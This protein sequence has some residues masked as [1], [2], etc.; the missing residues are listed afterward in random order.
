MGFRNLR[1]V[2]NITFAP[3]PFVSFLTLGL[4]CCFSHSVSNNNLCGFTTVGAFQ[5]AIE[6]FHRNVTLTGDAERE[7]GH[8]ISFL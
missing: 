8:L 1:N 6:A 3:G 5:N 7:V 2:R 4:V